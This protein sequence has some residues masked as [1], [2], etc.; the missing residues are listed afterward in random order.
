VL[1]RSRYL[2]VSPEVRG[3]MTPSIEMVAGRV[4]A[5]YRLPEGA[6]IVAI[7][8]G[9]IR[10]AGRDP[11][12][13]KTIDLELEDGTLVR[14]GHFMRFIGELEPGTRVEQGQLLGLAGHSGRTPHDRLRLEIWIEGDDAERRPVDPLRRLTSAAHRPP[15]VGDPIPKE[16]QERYFA[17][18][19]PWHRAL[20]LAR[21]RP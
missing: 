17:D 7:G 14:Y 13:G 11:E 4:G 20:R 5:V 19:E 21:G 3:L 8:D 16:Q 15:R 9:V 10:A 12:R 1:F 18:I 2:P 6:P